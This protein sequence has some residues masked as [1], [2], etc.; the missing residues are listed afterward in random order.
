MIP[1]GAT[2]AGDF[3][4]QASPVLWALKNV[5]G[6]V[7]DIMI[8]GKKPSHSDH[9]QGLTTLLETV[10]KCNA[11]LNYDKLHYKK[12]EV[13]FIGETHTTS[14]HKPVKNKVTAITKMTASTNKKQVQSFIGIINYLSK[15][16]A[17]LSE[18]MKP[19]WELA[20]DKVPFNW[21]PEHQSA[22]TQMK[23][24]IIS[25]PIL[26]YYNP[27]KQ[28]VLQTDASIKGLGTCLLQEEKPVYFASKALTEAQG[29]M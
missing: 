21:G 8:V 20:K 14:S 4:M 11:W 27:K 2:V 7:D 1:F 12:Q 6:I 28:T 9:D 22:F 19:I 17:R 3:S 25:A 23:Q 29:D 18:I 24:E 16:S 10:R 5:I 15:L 13:D 26:V